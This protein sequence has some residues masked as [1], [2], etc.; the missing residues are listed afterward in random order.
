[1]GSSYEPEYIT[2]SKGEVSAIK[3]LVSE[4]NDVSPHANRMLKCLKPESGGQREAVVRFAL[5][6]ARIRRNVQLKRIKNS[7]KCGNVIVHRSESVF[8]EVSV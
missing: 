1:M 3:L 2:M 7:G 5:M 8:W 4:C 6:L